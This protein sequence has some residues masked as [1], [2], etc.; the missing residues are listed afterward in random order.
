[1]WACGSVVVE[2]LCYKPEGRG[3]G[4]WIFST[5]LILPEALDPGVH[6]ASNGNEYR[7]QKKKKIILSKGRPM[8]MANNPA[9]IREPII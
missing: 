3:W 9:A 1:M 6:S 7:K 8:R 5:Y 2:A 4:E